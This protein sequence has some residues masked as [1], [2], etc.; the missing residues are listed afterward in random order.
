[1]EPKV[2]SWNDYQNWKMFSWTDQERNERRLKELKK[3]N[4]RQYYWSYRNKKDYKRILWSKQANKSDSLDEMQ[5]FIERKKT[6]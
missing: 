3:L 5:R 2:Y 1:M 4:W 6:K